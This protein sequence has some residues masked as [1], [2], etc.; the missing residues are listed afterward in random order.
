M[1][2]KIIR[3][4]LHLFLVFLAI[5]VEVGVFKKMIFPFNQITIILP[6]VIY[7]MV[8]FNLNRA[9]WWAVAGGFLLDLFSVLPF[10]SSAVA[11]VI[12]VAAMRQLFIRF[13]TNRSLYSLVFLTMLGT[14]IYKCVTICLGF[15]PVILGDGIQLFYFNFYFF[16]NF[17]ALVVANIFVVSAMFFVTNLFSKRLKPV[18]VSIRNP[19]AYRRF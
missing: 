13:F 16:K 8:V 18:Y 19:I 11:L 1:L 17:L 2:K 3:V 14:I 10:G 7:L 4:S 6:A 15:V 9:L 5:T 12:A